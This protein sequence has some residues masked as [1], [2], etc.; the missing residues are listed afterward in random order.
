MI[1]V[2]LVLILPWTTCSHCWVHVV[3]GKIYFFQQKMSN[4][5]CINHKQSESS[6]GTECIGV[7]I[8]FEVL[9]DDQP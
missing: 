3:G 8:K 7:L 6:M 1:K 5:H 2:C 4:V 9:A